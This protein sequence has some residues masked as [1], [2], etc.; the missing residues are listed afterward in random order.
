MKAYKL[1]KNIPGMN[2]GAVFLHDK[3]DSVKGSFG[4]GCLKNAWVDG[5]CQDSW[6]AETHVF[7]GQL[8]KDREW[9]KPVKTKKTRYKVT[10]FDATTKKRYSL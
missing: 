4:C 2:A 3:N 6:C 5:N 1:L 8:S 10:T 7:P 9:F